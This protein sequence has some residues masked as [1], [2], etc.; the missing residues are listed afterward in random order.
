MR[1][2]QKAPRIDY[3]GQ[4][5]KYQSWHAEDEEWYEKT[6]SATR[7]RLAASGA[8]VGDS[9]YDRVLADIEKEYAEKQA[10]LQS[11]ATAKSLQSR[12]EQIQQ[13]LSK[14]AGSANILTPRKSTMFDRDDFDPLAGQGYG[15]VAQ[16][17]YDT[18]KV[19]GYKEV[20]VPL[21]Q[22]MSQRDGPRTVSVAEFGK[23]Q[24]SAAEAKSQ[25]GM[26]MEEYYT[27]TYGSNPKGNV[28]AG[29]KI[30]QV[31]SNVAKGAKFGTVRDSFNPWMNIVGE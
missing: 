2:S 28:G 10:T 25:L 26:S 20:N 15:W 5:E 12:Y 3:K 11:G 16:K 18:G 1:G 14:T 13:S 21:S 8:K 9:N 19:T 4:W 30:N 29:N 6:I 7:A 22:A 23:M 17:D 27:K 31:K 24:K